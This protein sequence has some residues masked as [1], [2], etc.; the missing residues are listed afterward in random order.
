M[1][2]L[3][4]L[5][6]LTLLTMGITS[7]QQQLISFTAKTPFSIGNAKLPAGPYQISATD[8]DLQTFECTN[9][10]T[11]ASVMFE[12]D[13]SDVAP[14]TSSV[15]FA[16]Y[17]SLLVLKSFGTAGNQGFFIPLSLPEKQAKKTG[18]KSA[19]VTQPAK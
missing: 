4:M 2:K 13:T 6:C 7:A 14:S 9:Q 10:S 18:A 19:K 1:K 8:Q 3:F 16:K 5:T 15:T 11:R 17:G 12:A